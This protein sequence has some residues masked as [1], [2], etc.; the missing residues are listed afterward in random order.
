MDSKLAPGQRW[1][2]H[3]QFL[4]IFV[5]FGIFGFLWFLLAL[6]Y[7][8]WKLKGYTDYFFLVFIIIG[9]LSMLTEDTLESQ[10]GVTFFTF[11]YC[12]F[13][14]GRKEYDRI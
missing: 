13:L 2:S 8:P 10:T 7:P 1:R 14:F 5:A 9:I 6:F 11:F 4:S 3:N 12:F